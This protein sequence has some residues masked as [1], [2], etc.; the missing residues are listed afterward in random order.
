VLIQDVQKQH[1]PFHEPAGKAA[2]LIETG[3]FFAVQPE[4]KKPTPNL[5]WT[6]QVGV[7]EGDYQ[8]PPQIFYSCGTC[9]T[10]GWRENQVGTA[11]QTEIVRHCGVT[12]KCPA[13]VAAKY[14]E[15]F[16]DWKSRS[17]EE[18][19]KQKRNV[20]SKFTTD[21]RLYRAFGLKSREELI[22]EAVAGARVTPSKKA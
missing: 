13:D 4:I 9:G 18:R 8:F 12:E 15:L 3:K 11:H 1:P 2:Y 20:V 5:K 10:K 14:L 6:A 16:N 17:K 21:P 19:D 22:S 7:R